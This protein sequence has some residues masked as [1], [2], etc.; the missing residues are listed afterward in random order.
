MCFNH[1]TVAMFIPIVQ[2]VQGAYLLD[3]PILVALCVITWPAQA[4][5]M[6]FVAMWLFNNFKYSTVLTVA[7]V[8]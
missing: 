2:Q 7:T 6:N 8:L 5:P 1:F 3:K 4:I